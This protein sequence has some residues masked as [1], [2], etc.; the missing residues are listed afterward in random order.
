[1]AANQPSGAV[2][3]GLRLPG[4]RVLLVLWVALGAAI[5]T[6][7]IWAEMN[8]TRPATTAEAP[9]DP[10]P[11]SR[12]GTIFTAAIPPEAR[13]GPGR[14][15]EPPPADPAPAAAPSSGLPQAN[16]SSG[17]VAV[18]APSPPKP[19]VAAAP[20]PEPEAPAPAPTNGQ[21]PVGPPPSTNGTPAPAV[22]VV[23]PPRS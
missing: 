7:V 23:S 5:G 19:T 18:P 15:A 14:G 2:R 1:M 16:G 20:A 10:P 6:T 9:S 13:S 12:D 8:A 17:E 3:G 22:V 21:A 11:R 4:W